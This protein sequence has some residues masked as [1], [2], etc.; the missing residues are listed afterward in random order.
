MRRMQQ[1]SLQ[2]TCFSFTWMN[3]FLFYR[4]YPCINFNLL[5]LAL[6]ISRYRRREE[7]RLRYLKEMEACE[8]Y[9]MQGNSLR[10]LIE[11]SQTSGSGSG[12]PLLVSAHWFSAFHCWHFCFMFQ[13]IVPLL[14]C[15]NDMV[16]CHALSSIWVHMYILC[17]YPEAQFGHSLIHINM[18]I[19]LS[20]VSF[21]CLT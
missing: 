1:N 13:I 8:S 14:Y 6:L 7:R 10:E 15:L 12:L 11:Q 18:T 20:R 19:Q 4:F 17:T 2:I 5:L 3:D 9:L 16:K 21:V